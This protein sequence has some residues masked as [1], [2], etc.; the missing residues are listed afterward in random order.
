MIGMI[1]KIFGG[2][3]AMAIGAVVLFIAVGSYI[4]WLKWD[5]H[6]LEADKAK[7]AVQVVELKLDVEREKANTRQC[8]GKIESTNNR[9]NDLKEANSNRTKIIG[10]L[11]D[12]IKAVKE[13]TKVRVA[14]IENIV[15]P[16][17]CKEAMALLRKGIQQ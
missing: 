5:V 15:T 17:N 6:S 2:N 16:E 1:L 3:Q 11:K 9:I 10:M 12:N 8:I 7:L 13:V 14:E 4:G